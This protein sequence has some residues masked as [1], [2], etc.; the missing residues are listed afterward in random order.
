MTEEK[1]G[2]YWFTT[3]K[4]IHIHVQDG[5]TPEEAVALHFGKEKA[6]RQNTPYEKLTKRDKSDTIKVPLTD[7]EKEELERYNQEYHN[8]PKQKVVRNPEDAAKWKRYDNDYDSFSK[9]EPN[10]TA[11]MREIST[12]SKMPLIG[13]SY[14]FKEKESYDRKVRD[15]RIG[16]GRED[17]I[18]DAIRYTF[19][20]PMENATNAIKNNLRMLEEKGY[21]IAKIDNKWKD[22]GAYNGINVDIISPDGVPM[23]VQYITEF[24]YLIKNQM[25]DYYDLSR[26][27]TVPENIRNLASQEMQKIAKKWARPVG[28]EE[29]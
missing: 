6:F 17:A 16:T 1:E 21:K 3:E 26:D 11:D 18:G 13:L 7:S 15:K 29:V 2:G 9:A 19:E 4:G 25:H 24:N 28:I 23:E 22:D 14:R 12:L 5:Q 10:I 8:R 20:H 27:T